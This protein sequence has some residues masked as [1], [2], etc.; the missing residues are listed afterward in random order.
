MGGDVLVI[1]ELVT[2]LYSRVIT[3]RTAGSLFGIKPG[4]PYHTNG[5]SCDSPAYP[6]HR[7]VGKGLLRTLQGG[8]HDTCHR[9][10]MHRC[11]PADPGAVVHDEHPFIILSLNAVITPPEVHPS[12]GVISVS[13]TKSPSY[14]IIHV[15]THRRGCSWH[16]RA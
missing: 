12:P 7:A 11:D 14:A 9:T 16:L 10:A 5:I 13:L 15:I 8:T 4:S 3:R 6:G 2:Q 1:Y